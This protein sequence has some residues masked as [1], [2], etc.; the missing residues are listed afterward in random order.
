MALTTPERTASVEWEVGTEVVDGDG[1]E[2]SGSCGRGGV[3]AGG[4]GV[5][6]RPATSMR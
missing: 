1:V 6:S 2:S 4:V 3:A 5:L